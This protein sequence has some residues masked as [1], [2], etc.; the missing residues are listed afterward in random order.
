MTPP[1]ARGARGPILLFGATGQIGWDLLRGLSPLARVVAPSRSEVD[2]ADEPALRNAIR[3][4]APLLI[5]NAAGYTNVDGAETD[6]AAAHAVNAR[7]PGVMAQ[8]AARLR[9]PF[10]HYSTDYVFD[11]NAA[12]PYKETDSTR[13]LNAYG[14]TKCDGEAEVA[15]SG[16]HCL[17]FRTSWVYSARGKNFLLTIERLAREREELRVVSDQVGSPTPARLA[18]DA[19][20]L[21]LARC[22]RPGA[23]D[24]LSGASG[25]Y[26]L[27]A[28]G[29]TSWHGFAAAIVDHMRAAS[30]PRLRARAVTAITTAEFP[31]PAARPARSVLDCTKLEERFG[32]SLP[33]W[34]TGLALTLA[35]RAGLT[36]P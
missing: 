8:E 22:W 6:E 23:S 25:L 3:D 1:A 30:D 34:R 33:D 27:T 2:L 18:A 12:D 4:T 36:P 20:V 9:V 7:A 13:P 16:G 10:V 21:A 28:A 31:R 11:G 19:T 14:R 32:L 17:V 29:E 26:H 35:E 15:A 24:P 5:V